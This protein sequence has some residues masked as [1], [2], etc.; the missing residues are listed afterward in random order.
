MHSFTAPWRI[1]RAYVLAVMLYCG[2][3]IGYLA[4]F[5]EDTELNRVIITNLS[6]VAGGTLGS[7]IF[8]AAWDDKNQRD[9]ELRSR[10]GPRFPP[11]RPSPADDPPEGFGQ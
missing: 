5:G 6:L 3:L 9:A 10:D 4:I 11:R 1:R 8:G 7:Y 2:A